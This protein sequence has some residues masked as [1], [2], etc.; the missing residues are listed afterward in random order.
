[1][2]PTVP[3]LYPEGPGGCVRGTQPAGCLVE[4]VWIWST[5]RRPPSL[6]PACRTS[7]GLRVGPIDAAMAKELDGSRR[8]LGHSGITL[9]DPGARPVMGLCPL[10]GIDADRVD[11][12]WYRLYRMDATPEA[13]WYRFDPE[14]GEA[15][16]PVDRCPGS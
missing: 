13:R 1:M 2:L 11:G 15:L 16:R 9:T 14:G 5:L 10:R 12:A 8:M 7:A 4:P 3:A 6:P